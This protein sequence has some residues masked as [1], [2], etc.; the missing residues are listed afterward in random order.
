MGSMTFTK[1][2]AASSEERT[3]LLSRYFRPWRRLEKRRGGKIERPPDRARNRSTSG[4]AEQ[5]ML[6]NE[7]ENRASGRM[8]ADRDD[9]TS[10]LPTSIINTDR[11]HAP[12]TPPPL[13]R[14]SDRPS[15]GAGGGVR[16]DRW[17]KRKKQKSRLLARGRSE[18]SRWRRS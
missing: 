7:T 11:S 15:E 16:R 12:P 9:G 18:T 8:R 1:S 4:G 10:A 3:P 6:K 13:L 2:S 5:V 17:Q 14:R